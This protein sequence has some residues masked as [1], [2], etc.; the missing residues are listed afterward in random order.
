MSIIILQYRTVD[1]MSLNGND[2]RIKKYRNVILFDDHNYDNTVAA[3]REMYLWAHT[4]P[5]S[6]YRTHFWNQ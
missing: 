6:W 5:L 2:K 4:E 1:W 3:K